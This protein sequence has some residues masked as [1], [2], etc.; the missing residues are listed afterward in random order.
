MG[1]PWRCEVS[2]QPPWGQPTQSRVVQRS[3]W[4][5]GYSVVLLQLPVRTQRPAT[6]SARSEPFLQSVLKLLP[7][8]GQSSLSLLVCRFSA[9]WTSLPFMCCCAHV[10]V[11]PWALPQPKC[12]CFAIKAVH[13]K[14]CIRFSLCFSPR[15]TSQGLGLL[16]NTLQGHSS[17]SANI[18]VLF[19]PSS[20]SLLFMF[21]LPPWWWSAGQ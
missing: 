2:E 11:W 1:R 13:G 18:N 8:S 16:F 7:A 14:Y 10:S 21:P 19:C 5:A 12:L 4:L 20:P 15:S 9:F 3:G 17:R 6:A